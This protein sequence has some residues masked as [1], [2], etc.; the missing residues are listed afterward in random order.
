MKKTV[1]IRAVGCRQAARAALA[2]AALA[3]GESVI[4]G[5][6][7]AK[8]TL[9][10]MSRLED[11]G[12]ACSL[13]ADRCRVTGAGIADPLRAE[14]LARAVY[15]LRDGLTIFDMDP[16]LAEARP[17]ESPGESGLGSASALL[18]EPGCAGRGLPMPSALLAAPLSGG[19][20]LYLTDLPDPLRSEA[21]LIAGVMR[22]FGLDSRLEA[23]KGDGQWHDIRNGDMDG[24][25]ELRLRVPAG[26][27][28][29]CEYAVEG[30][31]LL[32]SVF[33]AAG[34]IGPQPVRVS[35]LKRD[36]AQQGRAFAA[37]LELTGAAVSWDGED[38]ITAP[39]TLRGVEL[40]FGD[41]GA[42]GGASALAPAAAAV[43]AHAGQPSRVYNLERRGREHGPDPLAPLAGELVRAGCMVYPL[44]DGMV[45]IPPQDGLYPP[46]PGTV[47]SSHGDPLL[48][49]VLP[50]LGLKSGEDG[51]GFAV[52]IDDPACAELVWPGFR[53]LLGR[54][55]PARRR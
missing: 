45:L 15:A 33:L 53:G 21:L 28:T 50:L 14:E 27:Y 29:R 23:R 26:R 51:P 19:L 47:F 17:L 37:I 31:W 7:A 48:A 16:A 54:M 43:A 49:M 25:R 24:C 4:G 35:G 22:A 2:C 44:P 42:L 18:T 55:L 38:I 32:A 3:S 13:D 11:F 8:A 9:S 34:A 10:I 40:D 20:E 36:S 52:E 12:A 5:T 30:D 1:N 46:R 6:P 41:L 39:G